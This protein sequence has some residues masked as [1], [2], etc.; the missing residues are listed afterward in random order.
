[1]DPFLYFQGNTLTPFCEGNMLANSKNI[2]KKIPS[3]EALLTHLVKKF[4]AYMKLRVPFHVHR[5]KHLDFILHK[6][7][8]SIQSYSLS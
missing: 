8:Q 5:G 7:N 3:G 1:M 2:W 4:T 6:I